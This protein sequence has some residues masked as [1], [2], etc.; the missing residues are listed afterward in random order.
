M[1]IVSPNL[2]YFLRWNTKVE[3]WVTLYFTVSMIQSN[4]L[5]VDIAITCN[6]M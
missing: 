1:Q 4:Y 3:F 2:Y 6:K 5:V